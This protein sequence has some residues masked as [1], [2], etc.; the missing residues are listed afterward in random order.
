MPPRV[1]SSLLK[2][3]AFIYPSIEAADSGAAVGATGFM[4]GVPTSYDENQLHPYF[5]TN[6]HA[7][8]TPVAIRFNLVAG[9]T[10]VLHVEPDAWHRHAL[11]DDLA[12]LPLDL[13]W[14]TFDLS[15]IPSSWLL[16]PD[17]KNDFGPGDETLIIGRQI[18]LA[19]PVATRPP[20]GSAQ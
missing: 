7:T 15:V 5:V 13:D 20:S 18:H 16:R 6:A 17:D 9:G 1:L 8:L 12:V 11:G 19:G 2:C 14:S 10:R 4:V 3:V